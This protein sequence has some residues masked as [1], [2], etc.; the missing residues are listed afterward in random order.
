MKG[1]IIKISILTIIFLALTACITGC[2]ANSTT[3]TEQLANVQTEQSPENEKTTD[4]D[5]PNLSATGGMDLILDQLEK[6]G[7]DVSEIRTAIKNGDRETARTLIEQY[8]ENFPDIHTESPGDYDKP[9]KSQ[10]D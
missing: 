5:Q 10:E 4:C 7:Y 8:I 6:E 2:V 3:S 1:R 9:P